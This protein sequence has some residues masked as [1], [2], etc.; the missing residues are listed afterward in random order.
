MAHHGFAHLGGQ[1]VDE[2]VALIEQIVR[3]LAGLL[4]AD[5]DFAVEWA[6]MRAMTV[7]SPASPAAGASIR[8]TF[9]QPRVVGLQ[10]VTTPA[11]GEQ[12]LARRDG[13]R[14]AGD[15]VDTRPGSSA[16][17]G[18]PVVGVA[19]KIVETLGLRAKASRRAN[20]PLELRT[21]SGRNW[22]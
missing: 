1:L 12:H 8:R 5:G 7:I 2:P 15:F 21:C 11:F 4:M 17:N 13:A 22:S 3:R 6:T 16:M 19:E 10:R 20:D 9:A 18:A 14:R